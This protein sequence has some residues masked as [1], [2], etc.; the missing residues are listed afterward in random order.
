MLNRRPLRHRV[1]CARYSYECV[2]PHM[3]V[4]WDTYPDH[5]G[6]PP[7]RSR[8]NAPGCFRCHNR[9]HQTADGERISR[10]CDLCH[11]VLAQR[12][13]DPEILRVLNP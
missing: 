10:S 5:S 4:N 13:Q 3:K 7:V 11:T 2:F 6:H 12:E 8:E 1:R 9:D